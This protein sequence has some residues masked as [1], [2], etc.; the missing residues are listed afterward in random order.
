M[1]IKHYIFTS[2]LARRIFVL[3]FVCALIPVCG[4]ALISYQ[5]VNRQLDEQFD[6]RLKRSVKS[7]SLFL[8]E[9]FLILETELKLAATMLSN[10]K[11]AFSESV[12]DSFLKRLQDR[13]T[14]MNL[15]NQ[16]NSTR[17]LFGRRVS[18][19][20]F[21]EKEFGH[22]AS[23]NSVVNSIAR[24]EGNQDLLM[25]LQV[26]PNNPRAGYLV[27]VINPEYILALNQ[28]YHLPRNTDLLVR[29]ESQAT[30]FSSLGPDVSLPPT[31]FGNTVGRNSGNF[32]FEWANDTYL[33]SFRWIFMEPKF[34][35]PGFSIMFVQSK[36]D[37][38]LGLV[39]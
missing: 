1:K 8:Y 36:N 6:A 30:L 3:F 35:I 14:A 12:E 7:Y 20:S 10:S 2:K 5:H 25:I 34:L 19:D 22:L 13:F 38:L 23:G 26:N 37:A 32:E 15:V 39:E 28:E 31:F 18:V 24:P 29:D 4:L 16:G 27:A 33:A 11:A 9:R 17:V 21:N